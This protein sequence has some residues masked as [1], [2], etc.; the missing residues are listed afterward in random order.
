MMSGNDVLIGASGNGK[1]RWFKEGVEA[2]DTVKIG[3][4]HW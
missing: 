2:V 3:E 4:E 1:G